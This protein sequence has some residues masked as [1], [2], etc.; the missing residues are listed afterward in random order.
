MKRQ[1]FGLIILK[2]LYSLRMHWRFP[3]VWRENWSTQH[4]RDFATFQ[5][6][7]LIW[8]HGNR[9]VKLAGKTPFIFDECRMPIN[10]PSSY[11]INKKIFYW[12]QFV[13]I[14]VWDR[15][16]LINWINYFKRYSWVLSWFNYSLK[17]KPSISSKLLNLPVEDEFLT[18]NRI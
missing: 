17:Q 16:L 18:D 3:C 14:T 7:F 4:N 8:C 1:E 10:Q 11:R 15:W 2:S 12:K 9:F 5:L 13:V 6:S